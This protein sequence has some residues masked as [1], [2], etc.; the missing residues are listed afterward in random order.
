MMTGQA[1]IRALESM[2]IQVT[3]IIVERDLEAFVEKVTSGPEVIFNALHGTGGEDGKIPAVL[4]ILKIP[5]THSGVLSS[6]LAMNKIL[7]KKIVEFAGIQVPPSAVIA[8]KD[9]SLETLPFPLPV[10]I[11]PVNNGSSVGVVFLDETVSEIPCLEVWE[12]DDSLLVEPYIPGKELTVGVLDDKPLCVT[13]IVLSTPIFDY[14]AKY[15]KGKTCHLLPAPIEPSIY[16]AALN[17]ARQAHDAL[18]CRGVTRV[19]LRYNDKASD[20]LYFL[21][22]NT[23]PGLTETSLI[24][25]QASYAGIPFP[26]LVY[27]LIQEAY[28]A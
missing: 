15:T 28:H 12:N 3:P 10:V 16:N 26:T 18:Q 22:L 13:E 27:S 11:K 20:G 17:M 4:D 14:Q 9:L 24:P 1:V 25:E 19:D 6:A 2:N 21:E 8:V 23:H 5:Y 7:S